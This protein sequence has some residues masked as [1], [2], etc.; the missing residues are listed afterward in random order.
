MFQGLS[1][2]LFVCFRFCLLTLWKVLS[3]TS[4]LWSV[5]SAFFLVCESFISFRQHLFNN[6]ASKQ[7]FFKKCPPRGKKLRRGVR[8]Q[9]SCCLLPRPQLVRH[10]LSALSVGFLFCLK[11]YNDYRIFILCSPVSILTIFSLFLMT[12]FLHFCF[13]NFTLLIYFKRL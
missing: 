6:K 10:L 7:W 9:C 4:P 8:E 13:L 1:V 3:T 5:R 11:A 12:V 2:S